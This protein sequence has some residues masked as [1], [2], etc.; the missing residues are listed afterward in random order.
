MNIIEKV[1]A[2]LKKH[3]TGEVF[4]VNGSDTLPPPLTRTEEAE[5]FARLTEHDPEARN[6]LIEHNL[7]LVAHIV[8]KYASG[9]DEQ[10]EL[11]SVGT[12]GLIKAVSSFNYEKGA[13]F[14]T[15]ASRCIENEILMQFR[16]AR[17]SAGD[18]YIN[19]PVETDKDGNSLTLMD[20]IDDGIDIHEQVDILIRSRQLY[21]FIKKCL[22][23]REFDI[24]VCFN[25]LVY[26]Y[27]SC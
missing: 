5:V 11:I 1:K 9:T 19:E 18:I 25:R 21:S 2:L 16:S 15:Y 24:I 13:K 8:K 20:L 12:I 17:K 22:D 14:A 4:Y 26:V 6:I 10:D 27:I 7:R 23:P 3:F